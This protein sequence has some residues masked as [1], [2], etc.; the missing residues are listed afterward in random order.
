MHAYLLLVLNAGQLWKEYCEQVI[1][2]NG[3]STSNAGN[4]VGGSS[5]AFTKKRGF[6]SRDVGRK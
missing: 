6:K 2:H 5:H 1:K 3:G 4:K